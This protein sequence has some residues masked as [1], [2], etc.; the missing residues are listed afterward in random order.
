MEEMLSGRGQAVIRD[1]PGVDFALVV[2]LEHFLE[3]H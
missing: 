3:N 2:E 1:V